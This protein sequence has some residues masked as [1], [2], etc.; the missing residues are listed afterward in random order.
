MRYFAFP[1]PNRQGCRPR[2]VC[3][4]FFP[5][6]VR[7]LA[8]RQLTGGERSLVLVVGVEDAAE[9]S[10][11]ETA[12]VAGHGVGVLHHQRDVQV[13]GLDQSEV[14]V[15]A[16]ADQSQLTWSSVLKEQQKPSSVLRTSNRSEQFLSSP[17]HQH[18]RRNSE[19]LGITYTNI[20]ISFR[21]KLTK[22]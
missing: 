8:S 10:G 13:L 11:H 15:A 9:E 21:Q 4:F 2:S 3:F 1:H 22:A 17:R 20:F 18:F 16:A 6:F 7:P 14:S 12:D 5:R 19:Q